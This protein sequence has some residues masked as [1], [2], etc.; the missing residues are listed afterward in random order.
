MKW[1]YGTYFNS[2][3][4]IL[5]N[6]VCASVGSGEDHISI[7]VD[8]NGKKGPNRNG[9]DIFNFVIVMN[10]STIAYWYGSFRGKK[11]GVYFWGNG[12]SRDV[13]KRNCK[14][15]GNPAS[16]GELIFRD[17]WKILDDFPW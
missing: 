5:N 4:V 16:C 14:A 11:P 6:G 9:H 15:N 3:W 7:L 12:W 17:N 8:F 1:T 2:N 10:P 13:L